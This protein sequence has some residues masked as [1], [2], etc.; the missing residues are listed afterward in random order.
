MNKNN[1]NIKTVQEGAYAETTKQR[2][3]LTDSKKK[4]R[5]LFATF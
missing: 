4:K 2:I 5:S 3:M 1:L